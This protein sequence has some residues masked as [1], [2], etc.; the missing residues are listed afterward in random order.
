MASPVITMDLLAQLQNVANGAAADDN[1]STKRS[2]ATLDFIAKLHG[3]NNASGITE[4]SDVS[5]RSSV[6][7]SNLFASNENMLWQNLSR[8]SSRFSVPLW[9]FL[10][11]ILSG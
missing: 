7:L 10:P 2:A 5:R 9:G 11:L 3:A 8:S 4:E 1:D 6:D